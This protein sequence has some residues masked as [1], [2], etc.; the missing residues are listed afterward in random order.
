MPLVLDLHPPQAPWEEL[1]SGKWRTTMQA[2]LS[3]HLNQQQ[4]LSTR[5]IGVRF[6]GLMHQRYGVIRYGR[7]YRASFG[8]LTGGEL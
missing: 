3:L 8:G 6:G 4:G 7:S 5:E 2:G 1:Q